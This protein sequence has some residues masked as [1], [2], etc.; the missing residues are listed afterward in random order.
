VGHEYL[1]AIDVEREEF[2]K[3]VSDVLT[4]DVAMHSAEWGKG[5]EAVDYVERAD[6][7]SMPNFVTIGE[8]FFYFFIAP[9]MCVGN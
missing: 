5:A 8:I 4:I 6:V 3:V 9:P 1:D 2:G 7:A